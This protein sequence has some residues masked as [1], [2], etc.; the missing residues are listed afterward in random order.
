MAEV[1]EQKEE[2]EEEEV[3]V[4]EDEKEAEESKKFTYTANI[5]QFCCHWEGAILVL[6]SRLLLNPNFGPLRDT[7]SKLLDAHGVIGDVYANRSVAQ[8]PGIYALSQLYNTP[9]SVR[10]YRNYNFQF[11][12]TELLQA[13]N[14]N[15]RRLYASLLAQKFNLKTPCFRWLSQNR[16]LPL[17]MQHRQ[18]QSLRVIREARQHLATAACA[19]LR[20]GPAART[21]KGH[22]P[23]TRILAGATQICD[24]NSLAPPAA[25]R[26]LVTV[27]DM[28]ALVM[29]CSES[30]PDQCFEKFMAL[31]NW[32]IVCWVF[33]W[34]T[35][36]P[37]TPATPFALACLRKGLRNWL[38]RE[39]RAVNALLSTPVHQRSALYI[40][41]KTS[42]DDHTQVEIRGDADAL[43]ILFK[44][45]PYLF[46][47]P[48][49]NWTLSIND[50]VL[51]THTLK[52]N[53]LPQT[54]IRDKLRSLIT[55]I[56]N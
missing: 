22:F 25:P 55:R 14:R 19:N 28:D 21:L 18:Q 40:E 10:L 50:T 31:T 7:E 5:F 6:D 51:N 45:N 41:I 52:A 56:L 9:H 16:R 12:K 48:G 17:L 13:L 29:V 35:F 32:S 27:L 26:E 54:Q 20:S 2:D 38:L 34:G 36:A 33:S 44:L 42:S 3:E 47:S 4:G 46:A 43:Q 24:A 30:P 15:M 53:V 8:K 49:G 23:V 39:W 37:Q 1:E 11:H